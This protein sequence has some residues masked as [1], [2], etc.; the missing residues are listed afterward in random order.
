MAR[1]IEADELKE[2]LGKMIEYCGK[3]NRA[4]GLTALFQ[5]VDALIDCPT[6][7]AVPVVRCR[8]CV[9]WN[10]RWC[11]INDGY[12]EDDDFCSYGERKED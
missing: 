7:D 1:L 11:Y 8:D 3:D 2:K 5:V 4:N 12:F 10:D 9:Y 6:I